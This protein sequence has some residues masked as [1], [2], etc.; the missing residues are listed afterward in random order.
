M[1]ATFYYNDIE[2][3]YIYLTAD[4]CDKYKVKHW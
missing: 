2:L 4:K 1:D 3:Y